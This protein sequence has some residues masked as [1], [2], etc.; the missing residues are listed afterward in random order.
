MID[1]N[2]DYTELL[3][4]NKLMNPKNPQPVKAA[5]AKWVRE[6]LESCGWSDGDNIPDGLGNY[7]DAVIKACGMT[8]SPRS[9]KEVIQIPLVR[10]T[11]SACLKQTKEFSDIEAIAEKEAEEIVGENPDLNNAILRQ[12]YDIAKNSTKKALRDEQL[13]SIESEPEQQST[14][15]TVQAEIIKPKEAEKIL[16]SV[17]PSVFNNETPTYTFCPCCGIPLNMP[18]KPS[19]ITDE[20]RSLFLQHVL[21]GGRFYKKYPL[22]GGQVTVTFKTMTPEEERLFDEEYNRYCIENRDNF[23]RTLIQ[24][25]FT[26][27]KVAGTLQRITFKGDMRGKIEAP[28]IY[29]PQFD[30]KNG[31]SRVYNFLTK[32]YDTIVT[33]VEMQRALDSVLDQYLLDIDNLRTHLHSQDFWNGG[34]PD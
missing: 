13:K 14:D 3:Q 9:A 16:D 29:D 26:R 5:S 6:C 31:E 32:W 1:L 8:V 25:T 21:G 4:F 17:E 28:S 23:N 27:Y 34:M 11:L 12:I 20:D 15:S 24:R 2:K 19:E 7:L 18:Y 10:Q 30:P 33:S 22:W